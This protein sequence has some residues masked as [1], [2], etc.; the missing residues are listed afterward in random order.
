MGPAGRVMVQDF[1]VDHPTCRT[2]RYL[3]I[4]EPPAKQ[5]DLVEHQVGVRYLGIQVVP[6][7]VHQTKLF[8]ANQVMTNLNRCQSTQNS[9]LFY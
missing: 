6:G 3:V 9:G 2:I 8:F 4:Q 5:Q 7:L 1:L